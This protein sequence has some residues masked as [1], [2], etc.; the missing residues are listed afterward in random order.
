VDL[1]AVE[2]GQFRSMVVDLLEISQSG[3]A[4]FGG[5]KLVDVSDLSAG[6]PG[7]CGL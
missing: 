2:V 4:G 1:L 3:G 7:H 5:D 6:L